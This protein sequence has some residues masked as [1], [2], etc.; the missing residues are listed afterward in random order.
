[1]RSANFR[2]MAIATVVVVARRQRQRRQCTP[3]ASFPYVDGVALASE[4]RTAFSVDHNNCSSVHIEFVAGGSETPFQYEREQFARA[5]GTATIVQQ[6]REPMTATAP[7]DSVAS[8]TAELVPGQTWG[9]RAGVTTEGGF[10]I[11]L[12]YNGYAICD[13]T[14][15][16]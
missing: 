1:M 11:Y 15:P 9:L 13:S 14:E 6:T 12:Y 3:A 16:F 10:T 5:S 7:T 8:V 4:T 2:V